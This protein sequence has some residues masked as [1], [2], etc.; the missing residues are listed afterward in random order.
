MDPQIWIRSCKK[1]ILE[2]IEGVLTGKIPKWLNGKLLMN[3]PGKYYFGDRRLS[4]MFD[5]MAL[6]QK[7][8]I[9]DGKVTY[10]NKFLESKAYKQN[11]ES[12]DINFAEFGTAAESLGIIER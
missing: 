2:P 9:K 8:T 1:E 3:G 6:I 4:H 12:G 7:F 10:Q 5:G 11:T